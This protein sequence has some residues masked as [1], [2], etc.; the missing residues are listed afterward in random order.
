VPNHIDGVFGIV[1]WV[2]GLSEEGQGARAG[3]V[4]LFGVVAWEDE[5]VVRD[6]VVGDGEDGGLDGGVFC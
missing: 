1:V 3:Y 6:C 4:E 5:D 2:F